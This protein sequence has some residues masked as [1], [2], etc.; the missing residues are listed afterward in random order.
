KCGYAANVEKAEIGDL[1][2]SEGAAPAF[3]PLPLE[4]VATPGVH[5]VPDVARFLKVAAKRVVKTLIYE[6]EKGLVA[7]V[8][9]GD[10]EINEIKLANHFDVLHLQ[11]ASEEKV[12]EATGAPVG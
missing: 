10:R 4:E 6:T 8:V 2:A 3:D 1:A 7:A 12:R 11:L 5:T 9:R